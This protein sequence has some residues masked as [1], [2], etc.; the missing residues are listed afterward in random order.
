MLHKFPSQVQEVRVRGSFATT[1]EQRVSDRAERGKARAL[2]VLHGLGRAI[3]IRGRTSSGLR[4]PHV[5]RLLIPHTIEKSTEQGALASRAALWARST[6]FTSWPWFS[7]ASH[8]LL[9]GQV[10]C[11]EMGTIHIKLKWPLNEHLLME[12]QQ[13]SILLKYPIG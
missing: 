12:L 2:A 4:C 3:D 13:E 11:L 9:Q 6:P 7:R 10:L 8:N 5:A 1:M